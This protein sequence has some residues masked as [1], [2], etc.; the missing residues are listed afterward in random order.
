MHFGSLNPTRTTN[1]YVTLGRVEIKGVRIGMI[2]FTYPTNENL[3]LIYED[4]RTLREEG[5]QIVIVSLHWGR[6]EKTFPNASQFPYAQKILDA[7]ADVVWGHHPHVLQPV[8]FHDGKPVF[9]STGNFVFGTIKNLDPASGI[10]QLTWDIQ[11]D[12]SVKLHQF[13]MVPTQMRHSKL[14]YRPLVLT[15]ASERAKCLNHVIGKADK[16]GYERLPESFA[17]TGTV[18]IDDDGKLSTAIKLE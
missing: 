3:E 2:G 1:R 13:T 4:I 7:G 15:D 6:E 14:E 5:C 10:F 16:Q 8:Y 11:A 18:Y 9:F 17:Q 12:G